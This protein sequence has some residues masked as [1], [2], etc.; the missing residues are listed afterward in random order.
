ML[1]WIFLGLVGFCLFLSMVENRPFR[2]VAAAGRGP[3]PCASHSP[4]S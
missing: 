1:V 2:L 4:Y 3:S